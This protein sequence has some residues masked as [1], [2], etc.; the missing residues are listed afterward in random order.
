MSY[1]HSNF[2]GYYSSLEIIEEQGK[3]FVQKKITLPLS[4]SI[5]QDLEQRIRLQR[6][7]LESMGVPIPELIKIEIIQD[8]E[9]THNLLIKEHFEGLDFVDVVDDSNFEFYIDKLLTDIYKPLLTST[10]EEYLKAGIDTSVRNFVYKSHEN[11]F[12]YVDFIPPKVFYKGHYS[13][14]LPEIE[15]PFY[16]IRMLGHNDRAGVVYVQYVNFI[17]LFPEKRK[18]IQGK[19][20]QFLDSINES[21]LKKYMVE[22]PFYRIED[23]QNAA[24]H[25]NQI[26]DWRGMNY[27]YLREG[28]CIASEL[29]TEFRKRQSDLFAMT[30]HERDHN[31]DEYGLLPQSTFEKVKNLILD[32]FEHNS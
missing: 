2:T 20:E 32:A 7:A 23:P 9:G 29:N 17:R 30:T 14:E 11:Q 21:D 31:S 3:K 12:C 26:E 28:I 5:V 27:Y 19:I 18:F 8:E 13:Q 22:S 6:S 1:Q 25:V 15:G 24:E 10:T 4:L 16:D